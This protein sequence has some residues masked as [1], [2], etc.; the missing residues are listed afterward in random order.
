MA[1][2]EEN[3]RLV[4]DTRSF[5]PEQLTDVWEWLDSYDMQPLR[6]REGARLDRSPLTFTQSQYAFRGE[7]YSVAKC[8]DGRALLGSPISLAPEAVDMVM[9]KRSLFERLTA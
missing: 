2:R 7:I 5:T 8:S 6:S 4:D 3:F 1:I 9:P